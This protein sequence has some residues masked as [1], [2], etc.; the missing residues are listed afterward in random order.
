L[1]PKLV[2]RDLMSAPVRTVAPETTLREARNQMH[3]YGHGALPVVDPEGKLLGLIA[4]RDLDIAIHHGLGDEQIADHLTTEIVTAQ[5]D[6]PL[7]VLHQK[8]VLRN[9]GRIPVL[10]H[11]K[12]VGIITRSDLVRGLFQETESSGNCFTQLQTYF[13]GS[14]WEHL[15]QL[16][17]LA[18]EQKI[19]LYLVGGGVRDLMLN[20][21]NLDLDLVAEG[22]AGAAI[23]LGKVLQ[24]QDPKIKLQIF[25]KYQTV[26]IR[27]LDDIA[28]DIA[29]ARTETYERP[30]INP[31]VEHA[32]LQQDLYRRDFTIN[33]MAIALNGSCPGQLIDHFGGKQDLENQI[34]RAIHPNSFIEDPTRIFRAVRF[35]TRLNFSLAAQTEQFIRRSIKNGLHDGIG[36]DRLKTE[37]IYI[38]QAPYWFAALEKLADLDAL[39]CVHPGLK[40]TDLLKMQLNTLE[41][42]A[43]KLTKL[44]VASWQLRFE[45][46]LLDAD[47][48]IIERFHLEQQAIERLQLAQQNRVA[49]EKLSEQK[50]E[51]RTIHQLCQQMSNEACLLLG[52][53][54]STPRQNGLYVYVERRMQLVLLLNG[55]DLQTLGYKPGPQL[56]E[57]LTALMREQLDGTLVSRDSAVAWIL[58]HFP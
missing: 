10:N 7:E 31:N 4:R 12:L 57:M 44:K 15:K 17:T 9:I 8:F 53:A 25:E 37:I 13:A 21:P 22:D 14:A 24:Q 58:R 50:L 46:L 39:R 49:F 42:T 38:L 3:R 52:S 5:M 34:V 36:G 29:T 33:A 43:S 19:Q 11:E 30:G 2:A 40:L 48:P 18:E 47:L 20:R 55:N 51:I 23:R 6:E 1:K 16:A 27:W 32:S 26:A 28:V 45:R 35:A 41:A 54:L 56:R